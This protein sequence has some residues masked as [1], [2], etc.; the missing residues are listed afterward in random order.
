MVYLS[1]FFFSLIRQA[2]LKVGGKLPLGLKRK[3]G[4][5]AFDHHRVID[6]VD[7]THTAALTMRSNPQLPSLSLS[8]FS[9]VPFLGFKTQFFFQLLGLLSQWLLL[10]AVRWVFSS[11]DLHYIIFFSCLNQISNDCVCICLA[12]VYMGRM[13]LL[14]LHKFNVYGYDFRSILCL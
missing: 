7:I 3:T 1:L 12:F 2:R 13:V 11:L 10:V 5:F 6:S 9:Y 4:G 14:N 8:L